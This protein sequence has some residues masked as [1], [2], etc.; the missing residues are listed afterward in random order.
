MSV[1]SWRWQCLAVRRLRLSLVRSISM[2]PNF[3]CILN[4][5][6]SG[7]CT[8][9]SPPPF[10]QPYSRTPSPHASKAARREQEVW[11]SSSATESWFHQTKTE[12]TE[13]PQR[14]L[15]SVNA[16]TRLCVRKPSRPVFS[17]PNQTPLH[18]MRISIHPHLLRTSGFVQPPTL[19]GPRARRSITIRRRRSR[20][21][22]RAVFVQPDSSKSL[23]KG[24]IGVDRVPISRRRRST[25]TK[26]TVPSS[27]SRSGPLGK[28]LTSGLQDD[29]ERLPSWRRSQLKGVG[30]IVPRSDLA[31]E[32]LLIL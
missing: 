28:S 27:A 24:F 3:V 19:L 11:Y 26:T 30:E 5:W 32:G 18:R 21:P 25:T 13:T 9:S 10:K 16:Q 6:R 1:T 31:E 14:R 7:T 22:R 23:S 12:Q 2:I 17:I 8:L 20:R 29:E 15:F 4:T